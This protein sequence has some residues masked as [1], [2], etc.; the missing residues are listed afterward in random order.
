MKGGSVDGSSA[1]PT[2]LKIRHNSPSIRPTRESQFESLE[3]EGIQTALLK[4][5]D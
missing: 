5:K 1:H 2:T 3:S 4:G